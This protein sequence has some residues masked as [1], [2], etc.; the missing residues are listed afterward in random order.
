LLL[1]L[2]LVWAVLAA[3]C[4]VVAGLWVAVLLISLMWLLTA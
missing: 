4:G 1:R 3:L 2:V